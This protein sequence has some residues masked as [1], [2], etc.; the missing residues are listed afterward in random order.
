MIAAVLFFAAGSSVVYVLIG[1]PLLLE[2][3]ARYFSKPIRK[4]E[5]H[6]SVSVI[7]PVRNGER[8]L[9]RKLDSVLALHYAAELLEI[10]VVS[11]GS[12]DATDQI[13]GFYS[14]RGVRLIKVPAG[15]KPAA[16]N[17]AVPAATGEL[18]F[19]TDV[20]QVLDA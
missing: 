5:H 10:I 8:W 17:A 16:L 3:L 1:Y 9:A 18:L 20:R 7:I 15:G 2:L 19:L 13:A 11:D 6:A 12:T 14:D 4:Q